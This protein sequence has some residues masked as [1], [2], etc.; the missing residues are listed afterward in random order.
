MGGV[1]G[2][3]GDGIAGGEGVDGGLV[4]IAVADII[5]GVGLE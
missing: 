4:G 1:G 2:K 5:G 3:N